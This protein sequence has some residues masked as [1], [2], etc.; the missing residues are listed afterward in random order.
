MKLEKLFENQITH[1]FENNKF[2][3]RNELISSIKNDF[4]T[5]SNNTINTY[6]SQLKKKEIIHSFS[7]G[8]YALG[9]IESFN[10]VINEKLKKISA[11]IKKK[12]PFINY[13]IWTS[14][15]INDFMRHQ[16]FK[17]Y[18]IIEVEKIASEQVFNL[19][20]SYYQNVFLN[21]ED[22]MFNTYIGSLDKV[23]IV[24]NLISEAPLY[25]TQGLIIPCIEK[26]LVD[27]LTD[28]NL[29]AAQQDEINFIFKSA[30]EKIEINTA[31]MKR[32]ASR[33]NRRKKIG[34]II[35]I[36]MAK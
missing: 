18:I 12:F 20:S 9:R 29:F 10:P 19:I 35:N 26:V 33:R 15:W 25:K 36:S 22:Y 32:Y 5:W 17:N 28:E 2:L 6:I 7:R 23:I 11:L 4:P 21:P 14:S 13:C 3:S 16:T 34:E 30:Y 8:V 31:K 27:V 1:Y 24:K